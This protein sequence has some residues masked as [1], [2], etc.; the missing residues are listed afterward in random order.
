MIASI[1]YNITKQRQL[2]L[3][4][5]L[6]WNASVTRITLKDRRVLIFLHT[7]RH[8]QF[9]VTSPLSMQE[10][11]HVRTQQMTKLFPR[12]LAAQWFEPFKI[13]WKVLGSTYLEDLE[14]FLLSNSLQNLIWLPAIFIVTT[15]S[16]R[17]SCP[18]L[19]FLALYS[20]LCCK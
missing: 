3:F 14:F 2:Y 18:S 12:P 15:P 8:Q 5:I 10:V 7:W 6:S 16:L 13:A 9:N 1:F 17:H 4:S 11:C 20:L 19:S